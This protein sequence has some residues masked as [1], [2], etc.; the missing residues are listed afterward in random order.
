[1]SD[2]ACLCVAVGVCSLILRDICGSKINYFSGESSQV[3]L[4]HRNA[5][6]DRVYIVRV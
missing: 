6:L 4:I 3:K 2:D 1:M 5:F